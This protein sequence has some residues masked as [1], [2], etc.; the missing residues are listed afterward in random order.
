[1]RCLPEKRENK[2]EEI[3][4]KLLTLAKSI[5]I[6]KLTV[7]LNV[8]LEFGY[9]P[10]T[11]RTAITVILRKHSKE[12][13]LEAGA[14]R[15]I[16]ILS[17]IGKVF[18]T[19]VAKRPTYWAETMNQLAKGHPGGMR[20]HSVDN[21][22]GIPTLWLHHK[23]REGEVVSALFLD[24]KAVYLSVNKNRLLHSLRRI[25]FPTYLI[26]Q[27]ESY[28]TNTTTCLRL[29]DFLSGK[30]EIDDGLLQGSPLSVILY[31][32]YNSLL[33]IDRKITLQADKISLGF[34]DDVT[35]LVANRDI[36]MNILDLEEEGGR[37]LDWG[38]RHGAIFDQ[39]K[40]QLMH[41]T[42][43]KHNNPHLEFGSQVI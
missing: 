37:S 24:G 35:H 33:L 5:L 30:F 32:F 29:Q 38:R 28:L 41:F 39:K 4:D 11:W 6:P 3:S 12:D 26:R 36:D 25:N 34:I 40:A 17:Y 43:K 9:F 22:V 19:V 14:Y 7:L 27:I 31:I 23:W 8:C 13:Y 21:A 1:M 15:P 42:H 18:E 10:T 16:A 2:G 20:Q